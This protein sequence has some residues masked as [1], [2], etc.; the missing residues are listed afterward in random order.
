MYIGSPRLTGTATAAPGR[1]HCA[2]QPRLS[3][4]R[5]VNT[6]SISEYL[7][8]LKPPSKRR[9]SRAFHVFLLFSLILVLVPLFFWT[10]SILVHFF[11]LT[12]FVGNKEYIWI[13]ATF[14]IIEWA[15]YLVTSKILWT[16][17]LTWIHLTIT[18]VF[19]AS[20]LVEAKWFLIASQSNQIQANILQEV[21]RSETREIDL[22]S[23]IGVAFLVGQA[24][25]LINLLGGL[26]RIRR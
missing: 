20:I 12:I 18:I 11:N 16:K 24:V 14:L 22:N 21:L 13:L 9:F 7:Q 23:P 6:P 26:I 25:F 15:I 19:I 8:A 10:Q 3:K 17:Y 1:E 4:I 2:I 5:K